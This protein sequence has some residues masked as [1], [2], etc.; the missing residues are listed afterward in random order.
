MTRVLAIAAG[1]AI[2]SVLRFWMS[3]AV[4][5]A[6]GRAF[7]YGTLAVNIVGCLLAGFL[8]VLLLERFAGDSIWR[9]GLMVG[10]LGGFTTFS[11]FSIETYSLIEQGAWMRSAAYIMASVVLCVGAACIGAALGKQL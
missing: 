6:A 11:A 4:Q 8:F 5:I 3:N 1:G 9:A 7:P 10:V 2:G